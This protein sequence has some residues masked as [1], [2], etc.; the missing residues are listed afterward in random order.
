[1]ALKPYQ[2]TG[3]ISWT[4]GNCGGRGVTLELLRHKFTAA[5]INPLWLN[6]IRGTG[7]AGDRCPSCRNAM[8]QVAA[9]EKTAVKVDVCR[10]CHLV[11][12]DPNEF[13]TLTPQPSNSSAELPPKARE[14]LAL[15][16]VEQIA[17]AAEGPDFDSA[18]PDEWWKG[19]AAAFGIPVEFDAPHHERTAWI[20]WILG[21]A[22]IGATALAYPRLE[23]MI[24]Q[25]GLIPAQAF[26]YGGFTFITAFFLHGGIFHL[27][28]N[29]YFL[30]VFGD[31]VENFL[32]AI[33]YL[34]LLAVATLV[35]DLAHIAFDPHSPVPSVGA[36]GGIA[37]IITFYALKFPEIRL[38]FLISW[39]RWIR[40]P[41]WFALVL[42]VVF[43]FVGSFEQFTGFTT[44]SHI[45]HLGGA[46]VGLATWWLWRNSETAAI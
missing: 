19:I 28:G 23:A 9:S 17:N 34:L 40:L 6:T 2:M 25:F 21:A 10:V 45:A 11:W 1:L 46:L 33:R 43:Q 5:S 3:G 16:R 14:M 18:P 44:V 4:C 7:T 38:G 36:S 32:G 42:W 30:L 37:G 29:A 35:G 22:I 39:Y 12:F 20:T 13:E 27:I 31:D 24:Q 8:T 15:A 41:A 26:R